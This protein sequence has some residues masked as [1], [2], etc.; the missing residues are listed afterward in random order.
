MPKR[1]IAML[2]FLLFITACAANPLGLFAQDDDLTVT[3]TQLLERVDAFGLETTLLTGMIENSGDVAYGSL[4]LFA[5][6]LDDNGEVI[7]EAFGYLTNQCGVALTDVA[8]APGASRYFEASV[9]LFAEG[10]PDE[11]EFFIEADEIDD[12]SLLD[13]ETQGVIQVSDREV[14]LVEWESET[15]L[16]YGVGCDGDV[17]T[18]Y[19]WFH[20]DLASGETEALDASPNE[21]FITNAFLQQTGITQVTQSREQDPQLYF[22]SFLTFPTQTPRII[23][24]T[25]LHNLITSE[26]DGSFKRVVNTNLY[27]YSLQ[28]FV[29]SPLANFVA[30][31]FGA[32]GEP[33]RYLTAQANGAMISGPLQNQDPSQTVPGLTDDGRRVIITGTYPNAEGEDVTG[34]YFRSVVSGVVEFMFEAEN[35][36]GNNYPAPAYFRKDDNTRYIYIVRD[37][38]E[39]PS[40]QCFYREE[41]ELHT[42]TPLPISLQDD[43]RAWT[44]LSP[45]NNMLA[46]A[47][48]GRNGGLWLIDLHAFDVCN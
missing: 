13:I 47:T 38:D 45:E 40:L 30:Y 3:E 26:R 2:F 28:G 32:F 12:D 4:T 16:R 18:E 15:S 25:D 39:Q 20:Y 24:Q 48:N 46:L 34:Y 43:E 1:P 11:Y 9:D 41:S 7:G 31:Y 33:V 21:A 36:P 29:W 8:I 37:I 5:D 14:V 19:D 10:E 42:L 23:Y 22:T 17:F 6:V 27:Q 35:I 44:F